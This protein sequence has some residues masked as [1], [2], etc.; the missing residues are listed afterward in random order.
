M[1][2]AINKRKEENTLGD[3]TGSCSTP[4][5][6]YFSP[7]SR[8]I[9]AAGLLA[10]VL[11]VLHNHR[12]GAACPATRRFRGGSNWSLPSRL[13]LPLPCMPSRNPHIQPSRKNARVG[14]EKAHRHEIRPLYDCVIWAPFR[15]WRQVCPTTAGASLG[16]PKIAAFGP[17][18]AKKLVPRTPAYST[19]GGNPSGVRDPLPYYHRYIGA[20]YVF[21][22]SRET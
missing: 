15:R 3:N 1:D 5:C 17:K 20:N 9:G 6:R 7:L 2:E 12:H 4:K 16:L 22:E 10:H 21:K 8:S 18:K 13:R 14:L 11:S 19:T